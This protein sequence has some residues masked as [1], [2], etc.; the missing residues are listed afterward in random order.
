MG[1]SA[2]NPWHRVVLDSNVVVSALLFPVGSLTWT[3]DAWLSQT[4]VP[5]AGQHTEGEIRRVLSYAKFRLSQ[6][7]RDRAMNLYLPYCE[8]VDVGEPPVVPDCRDPSDRPFLELALAGRA[9]AL[10]TGDNDLLALAT[11]FSVPIITPDSLRDM[12]FS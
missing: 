7:Q 10:V 4:I 6:D 5:L 9:D 11:V 2:L 12:L 8:M 1:P 3:R